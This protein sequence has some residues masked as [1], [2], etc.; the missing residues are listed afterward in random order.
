MTHVPLLIRELDRLAR[1]RKWS[2]AELASQLRVHHSLLTHMR[3][4]RRR[5]TVDTLSRIALLFGESA[6]VRDLVWHYLAIEIPER[7]SSDPQGDRALTN[8][9]AVPTQVQKEIRAYLIG[10]LRAFY[11]GKGL[12]L[13]ADADHIA[14]LNASVAFLD[15]ECAERRIQA[16]RI[17]ADRPLRGTESKSLCEARLVIVERAEFACTSVREVIAARLA[18]VRPLV[19]SSTKG[20]VFGDDVVAARS[21][22]ALLR[23]IDVAAR[24]TAG[25]HG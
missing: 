9:D 11:E 5:F 6:T 15:A 2:D 18:L 13:V 20:D 19:L 4:G 7:H 14:V 22:R 12:L 24:A 1:E 8:A 21:A 17:R 25:T 3:G 10:F 16:V 23:T